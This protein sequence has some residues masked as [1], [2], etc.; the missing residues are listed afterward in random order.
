MLQLVDQLIADVDCRDGFN[1]IKHV[2]K[3]VPTIPSVEKCCPTLH[4]MLMRVVL[5]HDNDAMRG[6]VPEYFLP[7]LKRIAQAGSYTDKQ[8]HKLEDCKPAAAAAIKEQHNMSVADMFSKYTYF[9]PNYEVNKQHCQFEADRKTDGLGPEFDKSSVCKKIPVHHPRWS[10]GLLIITCPHGFVLG[11]EL[12]KEPESPKQVFRFL[13][14]L[15][16]DAPERV[17]YDNACNLEHYCMIRHPKYFQNTRF[18]ID[19]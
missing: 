4:E 5:D 11:W 13:Y 18:V 9:F 14:Y 1:Y 8:L 3:T 10:P 7:I 15:C 2:A 17:I 12:I 6:Q 19:K 16:K